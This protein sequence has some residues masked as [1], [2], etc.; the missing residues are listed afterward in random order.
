MI[1]YFPLQETKLKLSELKRKN[2]IVTFLD[3]FVENF[4][5]KMG[6]ISVFLGYFFIKSWLAPLI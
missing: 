6:E 5:P 2:K 1:Q 4:I 3:D